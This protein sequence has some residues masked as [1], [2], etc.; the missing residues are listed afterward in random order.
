MKSFSKMVVRTTFVALSV[1]IGVGTYP[2]RA[3]VANP[4]EDFEYIAEHL[5]ESAMNLRYL[6]LPLAAPSFAGSDREGWQIEA[7]V[8]WG[9]NAGRFVDLTG[10][11]VGLGATRAV[12]ERWGIQAVGFYDTM[13]FSGGSGRELWNP[14]FSR[15]IPL[16]LPEIA[17]FSHPQGD[18][19]HFGAGG[20]VVWQPGGRATTWTFGALGERVELTDYTIAYTIETGR[21]AGISGVLDHSATYQYVTPYVGYRHERG[22]G[23]SWTLAPR[24]IG[25]LPLPRKGFVGRV[26]GPGFDRAGDTGSA[27][28]GLHIGDG[29]VG[30][31]VIFEH[32]RSGFGFDLGATL[33]QAGAE[34]I[35]DKGIDQSIVLNFTWHTPRRP[36]S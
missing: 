9:K 32:T 31:G 36:S 7:Q 26:T 2:V 11:L 4:G 8:A 22:L 21:S 13:R 18:L 6:T 29:Y 28:H 20:G 17:T 1:A 3:A 25:A 33:Y 14:L 19:R 16:D 12:S 35:I 10:G 15:G 30:A 24:V 5:P 27:G 34:P 23:A